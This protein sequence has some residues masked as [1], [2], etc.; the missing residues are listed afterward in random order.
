MLGAHGER[1]RIEEGRKRE[2]WQ[3]GNRACTDETFAVRQGANWLAIMGLRI[4][5]IGIVR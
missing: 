5:Q 3:D 1:Y 4:V 2:C